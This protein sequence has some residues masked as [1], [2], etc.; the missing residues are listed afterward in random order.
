M[1]FE[2][3]ESDF[4]DPSLSYWSSSLQA[5]LMISAIDYKILRVF[6]NKMMRTL[7]W[8]TFWKLGFISLTNITQNREKTTWSAYW[9]LRTNKTKGTIPFDNHVHS[10]AQS[11]SITF[12][13]SWLPFPTETRTEASSSS[14]EP[15]F[16]I[17]SPRVLWSK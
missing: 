14:G 5:H 7:L 15:F 12:P 4:W 11:A 10:H 1:W 8:I 3:S 9:G 13:R 16:L 6:T 2:T 17:P